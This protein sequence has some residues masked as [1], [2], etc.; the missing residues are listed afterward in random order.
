MQRTLLAA[1]VAV[2]ACG[3]NKSSTEPRPIPPPP[4]PPPT[5]PAVAVWVTT[6]NQS[7]L[8]SREPSATLTSGTQP[9]GTTITV[10]TTQQYQEI[11]GFG[12]AITDASAWLIQNRLPP[13]QRDALLQ[14]LFG[15]TGSGIGLS[16]TRLTIGASDFSMHHYSLDDMPPGQT[17]PTLA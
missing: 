9:E 17:D 4:V 15:R 7:K 8:M 1:V 11:V 12:A 13:T 2:A 3:G 14:E 16:F 5:G 10:D 6:A